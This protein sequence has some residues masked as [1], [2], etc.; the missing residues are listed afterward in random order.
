[1]NTHYW[2]QRA[3]WT[4][5][6]FWHIS[7]W[8]ILN[9]QS[10]VFRTWHVVLGTRWLPAGSSFVNLPWSE[11]SGRSL[12]GVLTLSWKEQEQGTKRDKLVY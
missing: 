2:T 7:E 8:K 5:S 1:M 9:T 11:L 4:T 10:Q 12:T 3:K 6:V